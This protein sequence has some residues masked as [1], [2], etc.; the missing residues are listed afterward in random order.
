VGS[1]VG[2]GRLKPGVT[3]EQARA[4]LAV[5]QARLAKAYPQT[6][7]EIGVRISPY[8]ETV[9][10]G[11]RGS[12]WLSFGAVSV[13]LLIA[14][15]NIAALLLSR[16]T[17][18]EQE[19]AL[20]FS[21]G[22]SRAVVAGQL[23]TETAL[24][25]FA[26]AAAGLL[27]AASAS[28]AIRTW[29]PE[30]P[31]L[32]EIGIDARILMYTMA[33]AVVVALLCGVFPAM[34]STRQASALSRGGRTQVSARHSVQWLLVGV[35][36]ALA[37][38]LL[39]A[40]GL[41]LR[42]VEA[43]AR[44][45]PGFDPARV[46]AFRLSGNWIEEEDRNR[47][48]QRIQGT[49]DEIS[50]LPGV[51]TAATAWSL[52]G[53]PRQYQIEFQLVGG[54]SESTKPLF[55]EW[56]TVSPEYFKTLRIARV[57]GELCRRPPDARSAS[58]V[59][60]N[61]SFADRYFHGRSVLGLRLSWEAASL[62]GRIVGVVA[63]A[64]ELGMDRDPGPTVYAC[65]SAPSPFPWFL[66]RTQGE[67]LALAGAVR[68]KLK[69]LE[70]LRSVYDIGLLEKRIGDA[71]EQHRLRTVLLVLFAATALFLACLGLYGTLSYVVGLRRREVGLRLALG[72]LPGEIIRQLVGQGLRVVSLACLCGLA[73]AVAFSRVLSGMLYGVSPS[74][75]FT[76]A[77]VVGIVLAVGSLAALVPAVRASQTEPM[78]VLREE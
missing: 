33:S 74:D 32:D 48:V 67:P 8:K 66:V 3:L 50:V 59:M 26:G 39:A 52:P 42:S 36:M 7:T 34:R 18:R 64:R 40:A 2:I 53:V 15:A 27:V 63:D 68:L 29:A 12:L 17:R 1:Y 25:A 16:A 44:V 10:G 65:N 21:L 22:A 56:R 55:A 71:Y 37:V 69:E 78:R 61:R 47:L 70:P 76:L 9:I 35:Q 31:R 51:Q 13:L 30:I 11:V 19:V 6:D 41:L 5:V 14:C 4:D 23:L 75:P 24:L 28:A 77:G 43:L 60:V 20:R 54:R 49:L 58:E 57:A 38:T 46:L 45:D 73:L 62:T 72:A